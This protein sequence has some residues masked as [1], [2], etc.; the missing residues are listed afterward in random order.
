MAII[1]RNLG[2]QV[3]KLFAGLRNAAKFSTKSVEISPFLRHA[4]PRGI[5]SLLKSVPTR[6]FSGVKINGEDVFAIT[7]KW[8]CKG[9]KMGKIQVTIA[10]TDG[11]STVVKMEVRYVIDDIVK[12]SRVKPDLYQG[13]LLAVV[14]RAQYLLLKLSISDVLMDTATLQKTISREAKND[15]EAMGV[16]LTSVLFKSVFVND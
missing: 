4:V 5:S 9:N 14:N 3:P 1:A 10:T 16:D 12:A 6:S 13:V 7:G 15:M 11:F 8:I 2:G